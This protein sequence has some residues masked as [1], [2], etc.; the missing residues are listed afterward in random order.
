MIVLTSTY[1]RGI[2]MIVCYSFPML[3][4]LVLSFLVSLSL[5]SSFVVLSA[6]T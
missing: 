2:S 5:A 1:S 6:L 4:F 3:L